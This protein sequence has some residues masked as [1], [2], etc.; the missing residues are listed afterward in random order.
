MDNCLADNSAEQIYGA[1]QNMTDEWWINASFSFEL[2]RNVDPRAHLLT[3]YEDLRDFGVA[4]AESAVDF[5]TVCI[6]EERASQREKDF[7]RKGQ[8]TQPV[9]MQSLWVFQVLAALC[10][11]RTDGVPWTVPLFPASPDL[12]PVLCR[13]PASS[14]I[15]PGIPPFQASS[16]TA[17]P[18]GGDKDNVFIILH[19]SNNSPL[20]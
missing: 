13:L 4:G 12:G 19:T 18:A 7:L 1:L 20:P 17:H 2:R 8:V 16:Q 10:F 3:L 15:Q 6:V 14:E 11:S 5:K 9:I